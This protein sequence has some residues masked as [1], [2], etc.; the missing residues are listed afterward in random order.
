MSRTAAPR[1][2]LES[3]SGAIHR[4]QSEQSPAASRVYFLATIADMSP[5]NASQ[6][7]ETSSAVASAASATGTISIPT[8]FTVFQSAMLPSVVVPVPTQTLALARFSAELDMSS[9]GY[10]S[11]LI[12]IPWPSKKFIPAKSALSPTS[13]LVVHVVVLIRTSISPEASFSN[14]SPALARMYSI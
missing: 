8:L 2:S 5:V 4:S 9:C 14:R 13:R 6:E 10:A 12:R 7:P 3:S 1:G 11:P